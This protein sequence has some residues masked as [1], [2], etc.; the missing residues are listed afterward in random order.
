MKPT[1]DGKALFSEKHKYIGW[2]NQIP[3]RWFKLVYYWFVPIKFNE[4]NLEKTND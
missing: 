4:D 1:N 2:H 3:F